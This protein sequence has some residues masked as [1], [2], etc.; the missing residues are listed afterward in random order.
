MP[1]P[2]RLVSRETA[3]DI[4]KQASYGV[5]S[6]VSPEGQPYGIPVNYCFDESENCIFFHCATTGKKLDYITQNN[7]VSFTV[8]ASEQVIPDRFTTHYESV[9]L[10]GRATLVSDR[11]EIIQR[12]LQLCDRFSPGISRRDEVIE[13]SLPAVAVCKV[14]IEEISGKRN[15]DV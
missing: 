10:S 12:L 2:Q 13:K 9:V 14:S 11:S 15:R 1:R 6:T 4:L 7:R 8:V 3:L 5:L